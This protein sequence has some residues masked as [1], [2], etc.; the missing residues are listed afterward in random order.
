MKTTIYVMA[1]LV[2]GT[3]VGVELCVGLFVNAIFDRLPDNMGLLGRADGAR[4]L[5]RVMPFWYAAS[6]VLSVLATLV[7]WGQPR[8][9]FAGLAAVLFVASIVL[10]IVVLVPINNRAK[11]WA[12]DTAPADWREQLHRWDIWHYLRLALIGAGFATLAI[13]VVR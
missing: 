9:G 1:L 11:Q 2:A 13:A 7:G 10:S 5:G 12:P 3:M 8:I 4:L 6:I